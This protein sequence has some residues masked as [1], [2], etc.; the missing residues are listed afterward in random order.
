VW[1]SLYCPFYPHIS[2]GTL[3]T[4]QMA[5]ER[6]VKL[7]CWVRRQSSNNAVM[8]E[9]IFLSSEKSTHTAIIGNESPYDTVRN[10]TKLSVT[11]IVPCTDHLKME[12][13]YVLL[14][15]SVRS[16]SYPFSWNSLV[17]DEY[18]KLWV[19]HRSLIVVSFI[20]PMNSG[21]YIAADVVPVW[22]DFGCG[23]KKP[24]AAAACSHDKGTGLPSKGAY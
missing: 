21:A 15:L 12:I 8:Q 13:V 3:A 16:G 19:R 11:P 22:M 14:G 20:R 6:N 23:L 17:F 4:G 2:V 1:Q 7:G 5:T 9:L 18:Y 24:A 10:S